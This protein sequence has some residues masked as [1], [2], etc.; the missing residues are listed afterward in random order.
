MD[1]PPSRLGVYFESTSLAVSSQAPT[2]T[3]LSFNK[4][5]DVCETRNQ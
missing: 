1:N 3:A 4:D 2:L 5:G